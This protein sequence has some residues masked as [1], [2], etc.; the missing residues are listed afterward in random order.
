[1]KRQFIKFTILFTFLL[2]F[3]LSPFQVFAQSLGENEEIMNGKVIEVLGEEKFNY[4]DVKSLRQEVKVQII[5][6]A[7]RGREVNISTSIIPQVLERK[8]SKGDK[9]ILGYQR[10]SG[11]YFYIIDHDRREPI[12]ILF[13]L[14]ILLTLFVIGKKGLKSLI[15]MGLSFIGI[16][17]VIIPLISKGFDPVIVAIGSFV[18]L[19]PAIFL[20]T[21]GFKR[22]TYVAIVGTIISLVITFILTFLIINTAAITG[23]YIEDLELLII[24]SANGINVSSIL[25]CGIIIGAMGALDDITITQA[26]T[27]EQIYGVSKKVGKK[28]LFDRAMLVGKD[29][30]ASIINT[31]ILVYTGSALPL[32]LLFYEFKRPFFINLSSESVSVAIITALTVTIGLI[33]SVPITTIIAVK[34]A[35]RK[36]IKS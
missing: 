3:F 5:N 18:V 24:T 29:H 14:F 28:E 6:G 21:H 32:L 35:Y 12:L 4:S 19:V 33:I 20:F 25:V 10:S 1:M 13:L 11:D 30:L 31:L 16:F 15:S 7:Q 9:L 22:K 34:L 2:V 36:N 23:L 27:V 17:F 8:I 26:S